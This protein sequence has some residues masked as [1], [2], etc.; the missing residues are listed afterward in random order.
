MKKITIELS[1]NT[2]EYGGTYGG[3]FTIRQG[4]HKCTL[5]NWHEMLGE[6]ALLTI[7]AGNNPASAHA[8]KGQYVRSEE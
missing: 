4:R 2:H 8:G 5:L 6:I 1:T 3:V 7:N